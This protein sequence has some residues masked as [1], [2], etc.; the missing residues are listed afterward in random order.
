VSQ[1][2]INLAIVAFANSQHQQDD[3]SGIDT[4]NAAVFARFKAFEFGV[5]FKLF[6]LHIIGVRC[7][8]FYFFNE[9]LGVLG[10]YFFQKP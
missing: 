1:V 4:V 3:F 7:E 5:T 8:F 2:F 9:L 10:G 6:A